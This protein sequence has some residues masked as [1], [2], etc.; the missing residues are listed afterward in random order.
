MKTI[1]TFL[2]LTS[3]LSGCASVGPTVNVSKKT[4]MIIHQKVQGGVEVAPVDSKDKVFS[5]EVKS[6]AQYDIQSMSLAAKVTK[7]L[8][9]RGWKQVEP[10][11][12]K[13]SVSITVEKLEQTVY[14]QKPTVGVQ[15]GAVG[16]ILGG[17]ITGNV[18]GA[19]LGGLAGVMGERALSSSSQDIYWQ[20]DTR[21]VFRHKNGV[22]INAVS[23]TDVN[24]PAEYGDAADSRRY[25]RMTRTEESRLSKFQQLEQKLAAKR[26]HSDG[27]LVAEKSARSTDWSDPVIVRLQHSANKADL[28]LD[29]ALPALQ[30]AFAQSLG[31]II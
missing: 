27:Q 11:Q 31:G 22:D 24:T 21:V 5:L 7:A 17:I 8:A 28:A 20:M 29:E 12:A 2:L 25:S 23:A 3:L 15:G 18:N 14:N 10:S 26:A 16:A 30:G 6:Q 9:D 19:V 1:F 4:D 13:L